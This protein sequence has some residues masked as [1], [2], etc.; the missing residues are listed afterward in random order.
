MRLRRLL[1]LC[2][3]FAAAVPLSAQNAHYTLHNYAPL[4]LNAANT[5]AFAGSV[6]VGGI[7]RG[8]WHS[9]NGI[10]SP[11][12]YVDAPLAFGLRKQD[13]IGVGMSLVN[14]KSPFEG[15]GTS[16]SAD[17]TENF[18]GFSAAYH[19]ALDKKRTNIVTL[20]VQY[21]S[22]SYGFDFQ[23]TL[24]Q[25]ETISSTQG[26]QGGTNEFQAT[27]QD[28]DNES[29]NDLNAGLK[30]KMMLNPKKNNVFEA[31]ISMLHLTSPERTSLIESE[32]RD[33]TAAVDTDGLDRRATIHAH[34]RLDL[35]AGEKWRFQPSIFFQQ[36]AASS[37]ISLQ[38]WGQRNLKK[39]MDLRLGVG[40]RTGDAAQV[41]VGLN[42]GQLRTALS[43][44]ITL[45]QA[46]AATNYQGAFELSAMYIFNIYKKPNVTPTILCP[47]I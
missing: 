26:G 14:S 30:L 25:E 5:G 35:E 10:N 44:D 15:A 7:F 32:N 11:T 37:A 42:F 40:Y 13:W 45:S 47:D 17:Y 4:W 41:L 21:G 46:R 9:I 28:G 2:L 8:Q 33:S 36:E 20:G 39:D 18:F 1:F 27:G 12:A 38:A 34:A 16:S 22:I 23:G 24:L 29:V 31:G 43:Y 6:R 3:A 19:L